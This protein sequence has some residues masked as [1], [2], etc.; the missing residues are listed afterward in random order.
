MVSKLLQNATMVSWFPLM[1]RV[2]VS[3]TVRRDATDKSS[4]RA[5]TFEVFTVRGPTG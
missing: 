1:P 5:M 3:E 2:Q 4:K